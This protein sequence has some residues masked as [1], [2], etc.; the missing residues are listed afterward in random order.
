MTPQLPNPGRQNSRTIAVI[1]EQPYWV[2]ELQR[3][4]AAE[5]V[6]VHSRR[7]PADFESLPR[8]DLVVLQGRSEDLD[9]PR[10]IGVVRDQLAGIPLVVLIPESMRKAEWLLRDLGAAA[11]LE[12]TCGGIRLAEVCRRLLRAPRDI[13]EPAFYA[14]GDQG[15]ALPSNSLAPR[16]QITWRM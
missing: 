6:A 7:L 10:W 11:I 9:W 4:L 12:E 16:T 3:Q 14:A 1:E 5:R 8:A 15:G 2:P 13:R